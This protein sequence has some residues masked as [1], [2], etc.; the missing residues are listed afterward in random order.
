MPAYGL[1]EELLKP[2]KGFK[3]SK[4]K[5][6]TFIRENPSLDKLLHNWNFCWEFQATFG[7]NLQN[8]AQSE[9]LLISMVIK[10]EKYNGNQLR[11]FVLNRIPKNNNVFMNEETAVKNFLNELGKLIRKN[12]IPDLLPKISIQSEQ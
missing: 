4:E 11:E 1:S 9:L 5:F 10:A 6:E 12:T 8:L 7:V 2:P 3:S